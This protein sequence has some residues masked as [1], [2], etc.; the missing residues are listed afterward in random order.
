MQQIIGNL[1]GGFLFENVHQL[2]LIYSQY[3]KT[4]SIY[5]LNNFNFW[6]PIFFIFLFY[7]KTHSNITLLSFG[8]RRPYIITN[9]TFLH[10]QKL[11]RLFR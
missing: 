10:T 5:L 7:E 11:H 2:K 6:K 9:F 1:N 4:N 3:F 8:K